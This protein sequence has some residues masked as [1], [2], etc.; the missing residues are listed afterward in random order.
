MQRVDV[1]NFDAI[2][3]RLAP[4]V[5][6][7]A[8]GETVTIAF[9][10]IDDFHPD[11]LFD[12]LDVFRHPRELRRRL[13]DPANFEQAKRSCWVPTPSPTMSRCSGSSAVLHHR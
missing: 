10:T 11:R 13:L 6:L 3:T 7:S 8:G 1:D 2:I 12:R 4:T 5:E 9:G